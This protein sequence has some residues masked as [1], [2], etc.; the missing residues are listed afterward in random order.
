MG[1]CADLEF[2]RNIVQGVDGSFAVGLDTSPG[3]FVTSLSLYA[4]L[5]VVIN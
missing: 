3:A 4:E 5:K 2:Y 1:V